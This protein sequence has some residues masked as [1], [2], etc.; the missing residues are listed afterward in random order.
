MEIYL[1]LQFLWIQR[2]GFL[3]SSSSRVIGWVSCVFS[4]GFPVLFFIQSHGLGFLCVQWWVSCTL[5]HSE[6][7]VGFPVC[8]VM[9]F[10][11]SSLFRVTDWVSYVISDGFPAVLFS[12]QS[13]RLGFLCAQSWVSCTLLHSESQVG[14]PVC[15]VIGFL[16]S[17]SFRVTGW[18]SCVLSDR[19]SL[20]FLIQSHRLGF[21]CAQW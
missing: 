19:F 11:Y 3:Y 15:S 16:Y 9:G 10:L 7:R 13:H 2:L 21:L 4:N 12:I 1:L 18:V 5:L 20:L 6:S 17:S 14:F 8:S